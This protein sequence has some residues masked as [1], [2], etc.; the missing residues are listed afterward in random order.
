MQ[1]MYRNS[2][3]A[4][5]GSP[6]ETTIVVSENKQ[7]S[8]RLELLYPSGSSRVITLTAAQAKSIGEALLGKAPDVAAYRVVAEVE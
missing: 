3:K 6:L 2:P 7:G 8:R 4:A 5:L 1:S